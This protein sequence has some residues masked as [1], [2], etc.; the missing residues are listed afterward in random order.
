MTLRLRLAALFAAVL[1]VGSGLFV[2]SLR[3]QIARE[4]TE[5]RKSD[6]R[7]D[8][9]EAMQEAMNRLTT[10]WLVA[11]VPIM[12]LCFLLGFLVASRSV[13]H[14]R[15]INDQLSRLEPSGLGNRITSPDKDPE[16]AELVL[17]INSLLARVG[18]SYEELSEFSSRVAHELRTPLTIL[19]MRLE[20]SA[21]GLPPEVSEDLQEEVGR[22]S[23]LVERSLAA[24]RAQGGRLNTNIAAIDLSALLGEMREDYDALAETKS[25]GLAWKVAPGLEVSA[26]KDLLRQILH[27]LLDNAIRYGAGSATVVA[28]QREGGQLVEVMVRNSVSGP[29]DSVRGAGIGLRLVKALVGSMQGMEF[30]AGGDAGEYTALLVCPAHSAAHA[31]SPVLGGVVRDTAW[32][33]VRGRGTFQ[34]SVAVAEFAS[35]ALGD[36]C[37]KFAIDF[38]ACSGLDSTFLGTIAAAGSRLR[39]AGGTVTFAGAGEAIRRLLADYGLDSL[40]SAVVASQQISSADSL[41]LLSLDAAFETKRRT[42]IDAHEALAALSPRNAERFRDALAFL[43]QRVPET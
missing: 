21:A 34:N 30:S 38:S 13:R 29:P 16:V 24:A 12:G 5:A 9:E 7:P 20:E 27:N 2:I 10:I 11:G 32:V 25:I 35:A 43:K 23:R 6:P 42:V 18:R 31:V 1:L 14:L 8:R 26:D 33:A 40:G 19:R 28:E 39:R 15:E 41:A 3:G 4:L 22:L 17:Q 36:G 37:K